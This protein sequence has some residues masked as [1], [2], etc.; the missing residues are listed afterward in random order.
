[1]SD[2]RLNS[3]I[4]GIVLKKLSEVGEIVST[5]Y[6]VA[7]IADISKVNV[8]AYIPESQIGSV[9]IGS[10]ATVNVTALDQTFEGIVKEIAAAAD[11]TTRAFTAKVEVKNENMVLKP[12][13]IADVTLQNSVRKEV[14]AIPLTSIIRT[15]EGQAYVYLIDSSKQQAFQRN[16]SLGAIIEDKIEVLSGLSAGDIIVN[17]GQQKLVNGTAISFAQN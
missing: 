3:T 14:L 10:K 13:M 12:G 2:T 5:G 6:P 7:V 8:L 1:M 4:N 11:V 9:K 15:S 17:G 16:I